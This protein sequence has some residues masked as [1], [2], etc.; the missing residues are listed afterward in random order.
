[1]VQEESLFGRGCERDS[2][3][4]V[5]VGEAG[6]RAEVRLAGELDFYTAARVR[7]VLTR[8]RDAGHPLVVVDLAGLEFLGARGLEVFVHATTAY[9]AAGVRLVLTGITGRVRRVLELMSLD[10]VLTI[11]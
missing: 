10:D 8:L 2:L 5:R 6:G 11:A 3:L 7:A 9:R 4:S 1:V